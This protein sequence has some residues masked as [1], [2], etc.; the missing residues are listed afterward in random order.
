M[1]S[2]GAIFGLF[3]DYNI[4]TKADE[5]GYSFDDSLVLSYIDEATHRGKKGI[6]VFEKISLEEKLN[7]CCLSILPLLKPLV[8]QCRRLYYDSDF[9]DEWH[10]N[11]KSLF[12]EN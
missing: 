12:S 3:S 11:Y 9:R 6:E 2:I 7:L 10:S 5:K 8:T 4:M 1:G